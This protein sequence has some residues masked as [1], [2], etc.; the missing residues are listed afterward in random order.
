MTVTINRK[1]V[2]MNISLLAMFKKNWRRVID[3]ILALQLVTL[4][5]ASALMG[6]AKAGDNEPCERTTIISSNYLWREASGVYG[7]TIRKYS[8]GVITAWMWRGRSAM[9]SGDPY[10]QKYAFRC[11]SRLIKRQE[12]EYSGLTEEDWARSQSGTTADKWLTY[13][14]KNAKFY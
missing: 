12:D 8:N 10:K 13:I 7:C 11:S 3:C 5:G 6:E 14:C 9:L 1:E 2:V 4:L